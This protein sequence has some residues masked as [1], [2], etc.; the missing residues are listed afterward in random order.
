LKIF[1]CTPALLQ[2]AVAD[3]CVALSPLPPPQAVKATATTAQA[4]QT[5]LIFFIP[6]LEVLHQAIPL[7][8]L[9]K[10]CSLFH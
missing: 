2:S 7:A 3:G 5:H 10:K 6:S 4:I 9:G 1:G 8:R